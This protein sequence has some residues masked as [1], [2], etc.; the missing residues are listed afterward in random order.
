MSDEAKAPQVPQPDHLEPVDRGAAAEILVPRQLDAL[1]GEELIGD[2]G[3]TIRDFWSWSFSDL[4]S[5]TERGVFAEY[6]VAR[7][8]GDQTPLRKSWANH[9][10]TTPSGIRIE[11]KAS[12]YL[13][14]WHQRR[15]SKL[16]FGRLMA[17]SWDDVSGAYGTEAEVRADVYVFAIQTCRDPD[18]YDV[19]NLNQW[20]FRVV[21]A[22][23][24]RSSPVKSVGMAFLERHAP[25][26]LQWHELAAAIEAAGA[27]GGPGATPPVPG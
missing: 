22:D 4:R 19:L 12:G 9:D 23:V 27:H 10:V 8:V 16:N 14:S 5:N 21:S 18:A 13:Q 3:S 25:Q 15:H 24:V 11:V 7:A 2:T 26:S 1:G 6:L 17:L 20:E